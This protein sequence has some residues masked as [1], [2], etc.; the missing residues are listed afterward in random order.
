MGLVPVAVVHVVLLLLER[1]L[2]HLPSCLVHG[3]GRAV[4]PLFRLHHPW[5]VA[6][7]SYRFTP[8]EA[9]FLFGELLALLAMGLTA[10]WLLFMGSV[11]RSRR[12]R[13]LLAVVVIGSIGVVGSGFGLRADPRFYQK[14]LTCL[15]AYGVGGLTLLFALMLATSRTRPSA[16]R[17]CVQVLLWT[18]A[19]SI[20][21]ALTHFAGVVLITQAP[22]YAALR[23]LGLGT[24]CGA[25]LG[26]GL[27]VVALVFIL[28]TL[29]SPFYRARLGP[30]LRLD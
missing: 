6:M 25:A 4:S 8:S 21:M 1:A 19:L 11:S 23:L 16:V 17:L 7:G 26:L 24:L 18:V 27:A 12:E 22:R 9:V 2:C 28:L 14:P 29:R 10:V 15:F 5:H 20:G 13:F 30:W 3:L